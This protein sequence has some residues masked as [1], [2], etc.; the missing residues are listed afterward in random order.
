[1]RHPFVFQHRHQVKQS[2]RTW[3]VGEQPGSA[4]E[5]HR[6][7]VDPHLVEQAGCQALVGDSRLSGRGADTQPAG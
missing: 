4:T 6:D 1:M 3:N 2:R 7:Q 5:Q